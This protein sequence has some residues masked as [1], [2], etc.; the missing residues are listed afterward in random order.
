MQIM[1]IHGSKGLEAPVVVAYDIFATGTRDSTFSSSENVL[2]TPDIIAG[3]IHPW[4][5]I[6]KPQSGLW[7]I[8]HLFDDGQQRAERRRQF[9]VALTRARDRLIIAGGPNNGATLTSDGRIQMKRGKG[10]Q[11]MGYMF[12]DGLAHA[13]IQAGEE[14]CSW[15]TGGLDQIGKTLTLDPAS[16]FQEAHLGAECVTGISIFH[17]PDCF[18]ET[19]PKSLVESWRERMELAQ[20]PVSEES[21]DKIRK[22]SFSHPMTSHGLDTAWACN[23]RHW[24]SSKL[25]WNAER[26]D[27]VAEESGEQYWPSATE[28]GSLF[29][30]LLEIGLANPGSQ[31]TD[32]NSMWTR[33][34]QDNLTNEKTIEEVMAQS[35]IS[36]AEVVERTRLRLLHLGKLAREGALGKLV[37]GEPYDGFT[38]EG[39]RTELP[40]YFSVE[41]EPNS[42]HRTT[43]SPH[44]EQ[45]ISLVE[46]ISAVFN[47]RADLVLALRDDSGQGWLQV[48]DAKTKQCLAGFNPR[49]PLEG[50]ELQT[51][52]DKES[53][54]ASTPAEEEIIAEHRLQLALYSLALEI[55]ENSKPESERRKILPPAI[56]VS[57]SG[58]MIRMHDEDF[59]Q[60][61]IDLISL[62]EWSGEIAAAGEGVQPPQRLPMSQEKT[63]QTCPFYRGTIKLCGPIDEKLGPS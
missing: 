18:E 11:N 36:D 2:V 15:S 4:R 26:M 51:V 47:G 45:V 42:L 39:L 27:L 57:A 32:L 24:L 1:T 38:V 13:S 62:V 48:V 30:R 60:A 31:S 34:Q 43:W 59:K 41:H 5:G 49:C 9:Y 28:F 21:E 29:H 22:I 17:H 61:R 40:F 20:T 50:N 23:R 33:K 53:P 8:A 63:C 37:S 52:A 58:R 56:Q 19:P 25:N 44:G 7:T 54:Y 35:T 10:R 46:S 14:G 3:R 12:L 16:L 6:S 55:A